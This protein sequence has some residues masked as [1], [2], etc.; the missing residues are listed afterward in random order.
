[1]LEVGPTVSDP[2]GAHVKNIAD[3]RGVRARAACAR[4]APAARETSAT[5]VRSAPACAPPGPAPGCSP[6]D[7]GVEGE[8]GLPVA[9]MSS[10][11]GGMGAH[12]TGA[13][14]RPGEGER[15]DGL[16]DLDELLGEAE[17][18]LGVTT[19]AFVARRSPR[20]ARA[21]QRRRRCGPQP[22]P[23][24]Q[25]MPLAVHRRADGSLVWSGA[26]VVFGD[27]SRA[28]PRLRLLDESLVRR[29]LVEDGRAAGV[30]VEDRRTGE[31]HAVARA[32]VS[33]P[34]DGL[35]T[36]QLLWASGMRP[37]ALG[38]Y[39]NDQAQVVFAVRLRGDFEHPAPPRRGPRGTG[40]AS[41]AG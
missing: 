6:T 12:W 35:R 13:C 25:R 2:P 5:P 14:P 22:G 8:D 39:L 41:T 4:R 15:I 7:A 28:N 31:R 24:V 29:V 26:D 16:D 40:S 23:R 34:R 20:G 17:R 36:P 38:R 33:W 10:N 19:D 9:A 18:L 21:A 37:A 3:A 30:E 1:M 27:A 11:V 32:V